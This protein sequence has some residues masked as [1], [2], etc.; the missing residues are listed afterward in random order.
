MK[1][2]K[3][4]TIISLIVTVVI[5]LILAGITIGSISGDDSIIEQTGETAQDAQKESIIQKIK[6]EL[7]SEQV[8]SGK[9]PSKEK[10][11]EIISE[12]F[13]TIDKDGENELNSFTSK[14][15]K[16]QISF[17]DI[18]GWQK[19]ITEFVK[20]GDYVDYEPTKKDVN[21]TQDVESS[22]LTYTSPTGTIPTESTG[23]ITHG[24]GYTSTEEDGGQTF[25]AKTNDG[26]ETGL[27]WIVLSVSEDKVELISDKVVKTDAGNNFILQG[28]IGY[29]YVGQELNE[30]CKIYGYGY[31]ADTRLGST[32]NIGYLEDATTEKIEGTGARSISIED[33][34]KAAGVYKDETDEQMKYSDGTVINSNYGSD[35]ITAKLFYYPSIYSTSTKNPGQSKGRKTEFKYTYYGYKQDKVTDTNLRS[36]LFGG[37]SYWL[38]EIYADGSIRWGARYVSGGQI[39]GTPLCG[40]VS[41]YL[42]Q[43]AAGSGYAVRPIVTLKSNAI[44]IAKPIIDE[45]NITTW[46]LK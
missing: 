40:G 44:N 3:G 5:L 39:S 43:Y 4:I 25:T 2:N 26:T 11:K 6:A 37:R 21:R 10:L 7:Y 1:K 19:P 42:Y 28:G 31:G 38:P 41:T 27:K 17:F 29:L 15:G 12:N 13:G 9:V 34:N 16:Y 8:K 46:K 33:I 35:I 45:N 23:I 24:N 36:V 18:E 20:V 30:I 22:K 14:D 32:Y